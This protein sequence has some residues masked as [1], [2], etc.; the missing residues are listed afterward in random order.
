MSSV[1]KIAD[2]LVDIKFS[3]IAWKGNDGF[4]YSSYDK[5]KEGSKLSGLTQYHKLFYHKLGTSQKEDK[6]IFGGNKQKRRYLGAYLTEDQRF[7]VITAAESTS[8][9]ELCFK[10]LSKENSKITPIMT[11]FDADLGIVDN[12]GSRLLISTNYNAPNNR[13]V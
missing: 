13:L 1:I 9:N 10:D 2:T 7:L 6:L 4:Y 3:G 12:V 8:G 5:P 11:G